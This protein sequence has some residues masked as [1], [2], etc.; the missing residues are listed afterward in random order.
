MVNDVSL[1]RGSQGA[2]NHPFGSHEMETKMKIVKPTSC[3]LIATVLLLAG[4][5]VS[6]AEKL[7]NILR[8][9]KWDGIIGTWVDPA[10]KNT[11]TFAWKI[12]DRV[13]EVTSKEKTKQTVALMGVN[14]KTGEVFHMGANSD[15][16]SV[17]GKWELEDEDAVLGLLYTTGDGQE[18]ALSIRYHREN[19]DTLTVIVELPGVP[20]PIAKSRLIRTKPKK[21]NK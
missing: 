7:S 8:K 13:I 1:F 11:T 18:G 2:A 12:E 21:S 3:I 5:Q 16:T 9:A 14:A 17:L 4:S 10:T 19:A 6:A 15:G 20:D